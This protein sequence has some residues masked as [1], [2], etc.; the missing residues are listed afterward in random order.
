MLKHILLIIVSLF[1]LSSFSFDNIRSKC[2]YK[3]GDIKFNY[4]VIDDHLLISL[5]AKTSGWIALGFNLKYAMKDATIII[6]YFDN[7]KSV[8]REDYG[9]SAYKHSSISSLG[10]KYKVNLVSGNYVDG[11]TNLIFKMPLRPKDIKYGANISLDKQIKIILAYGEN[12]EKNFTSYHKYRDISY[13]I[14]DST[15]K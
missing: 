6:G 15:C 12:N 10:G 3:K 8:I 5:K 9:I 2:F 4:K 11:W 13:I 1:P 7:S 14:I